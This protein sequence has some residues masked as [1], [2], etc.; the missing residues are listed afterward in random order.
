[1]SFT[2]PSD[3]PKPL[4]HGHASCLLCRLRK[5]HSEAMWEATRAGHNNIAACPHKTTVHLAVGQPTQLGCGLLAGHPGP[6]EFHVEWTHDY[7]D[8]EVQP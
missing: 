3:P 5:R 7:G 4:E 6:H 2:V 8:S 1:M